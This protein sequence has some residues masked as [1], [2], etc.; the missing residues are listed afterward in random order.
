VKQQGPSKGFDF[1]MS[2]VE[3]IFDLLLKEKQL[4]FPEGCKVPTAQELRGD[5]TTSGITLSLAVLVTAR[6][7]RDR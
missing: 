5:H 3:Q 6:N 1:D 4:K 7:S 2:K